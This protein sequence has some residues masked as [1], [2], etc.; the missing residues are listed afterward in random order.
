MLAFPELINLVEGALVEAVRQGA[1]DIHI[2]PFEKD[3]K[4]RYRIDGILIERDSPPRRLL[5][6]VLSRVKILS[7]LDIA[8]RR[9]TQDGRIKVRLG[10]KTLDLRISTLPTQYGET[11]VMRVLDP[12]ASMIRRACRVRSSVCPTS[13]PIRLPGSRINVGRRPSRSKTRRE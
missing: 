2:E 10:E 8:E 12:K 4:V 11:V 5:G 3:L 9:R 13:E 1:S 7:K 6:A